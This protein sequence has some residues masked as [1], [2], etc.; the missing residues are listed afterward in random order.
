[1]RERQTCDAGGCDGLRKIDGPYLIAVP[2]KQQG[3]VPPLRTDIEDSL[4]VYP[5]HPALEYFLGRSKPRP[6]LVQMAIVRHAVVVED[7]DA[8]V[9][10]DHET[11]AMVSAP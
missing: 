11:R 8:G 2:G 5:V 10:R 3:L 6:M 9:S 4:P 7:L 1:M